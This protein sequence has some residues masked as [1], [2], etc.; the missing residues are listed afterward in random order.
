MKSRTLVPMF[1]VGV[2]LGAVWYVT[3]AEMK[4]SERIVREKQI[5]KLQIE[6]RDTLRQMLEA[7][8]ASYEAG[9]TTAQAVLR[10]YQ[11]ELDAE[12]VVAVD[13]AHRVRI[14]EEQVNNLAAFE[15][16]IVS[17]HRQGAHGGESEALLATRAARL[18]AEIMLLQQKNAS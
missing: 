9:T 15:D 13:N 17:L 1:V 5:V 8:K 4:S 3:A 12:L 7:T 16:R 14:L 10:A 18:Q 6:C 11:V 2:I